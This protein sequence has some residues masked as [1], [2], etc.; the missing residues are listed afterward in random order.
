MYSLNVKLISQMQN[1]SDHLTGTES[2]R[3][4]RVQHTTGLDSRCTLFLIYATEIERWAKE[5][6]A[7]AR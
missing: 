4:L 1:H 2:A 7:F 6:A 5:A 3:L